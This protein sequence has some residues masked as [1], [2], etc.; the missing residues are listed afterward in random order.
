MVKYTFIL[1]CLNE[2]KTLPICIEEIRNYI[3]KKKLNAEILVADNGSSDNSVSIAKKMGVRI[4]ICDKKGYGSNLIN[5]TKNSL[6]K[7]C[8]MGDADGSYDFSNLDEFINKVLDGYDLVVGNRFMGGIEKGA[9]PLSHKIG[10]KM[11]SMYSNLFFKTP[12]KDYHCGLRVYNRK[13]IEK[14]CLSSTGMEYASEMII[15]SQI[16]NLK[17][18]QVSTILRKD[19]REKKSHLKV[20][21]DGFRHLFLITHI[22]MHRNKYLINGVNNENKSK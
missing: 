16:N 6:G 18:C 21:R 4:C 1:P 11:L 2:E 15:K 22:Y 14:L 7:Y 12:I 13:S 8:I 3:K 10:V 5:G 19:L 17:I 20:F 9:M